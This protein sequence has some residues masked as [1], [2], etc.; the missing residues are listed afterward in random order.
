MRIWHK[1]LI[2]ILP[3]EQLVAQWRELSA[4]AGAVQ[5]NGTPNHTLVN[6][7][8]DYDFDHFIS[9]AKAIREEMT[10]RGY[11]TSDAV[12]DKIVSLKPDW[13]EISFVNIYKEKFND[14]YFM[15]CLNNLMEKISTGSITEQPY[16]DKIIQM[17][18]YSTNAENL[19]YIR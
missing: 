2:P 5:K 12:W 4:I 9:Y 15:I 3:R 7:I 6:F 10:F 1:N 13:N 19:K 18:N 8:L 16:T 14:F 11:R 17:Y